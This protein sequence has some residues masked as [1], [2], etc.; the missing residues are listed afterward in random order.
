LTLVF[1]E[2]WKRVLS[3]D[4]KFVFA[5]EIEL[6]SVLVDYSSVSGCLVAWHLSAKA[7]RRAPCH[8]GR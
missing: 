8:G 1:G 6:R 2:E 3:Y 7:P 4:S 5:A